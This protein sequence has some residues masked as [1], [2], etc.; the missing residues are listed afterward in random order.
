MASILPMP[1]RAMAQRRP[2][3][4]AILAGVAVALTLAF[5][6]NALA[7]LTRVLM[8]WDAGVVTY[9]VSL[10]W[11]L[12]DASPAE[13]TENAVRLDEGRHF[14]LAISLVGVIACIAV[15]AFELTAANATHGDQGWRVGFVFLTVALSWLFVHASF[16]SHYAHE[17]YGPREEGEVIRGGLL[18]PGGEQPDFADFWHFSVVIGVA[19]QTA[20]VQITTKPV[21]RVVTWHGIFAFLFNTVILALT[22]NFA[23]SF[24]G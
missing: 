23:A 8:A 11:L 20:D 16:A 10:F 2:L 3:R 5:L 17:Y 24:F 15:I 14:V 1:I 12:R 9:L 7:P 6:P 4:W 18:F 13:M 22:I 19:C 21:R